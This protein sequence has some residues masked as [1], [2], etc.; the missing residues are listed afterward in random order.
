MAGNIKISIEGGSPE[1]H[2][3]A[4][5]LI[6]S[7]LNKFGLKYTTNKVEKSKTSKKLVINFEIEADSEEEATEIRESLQPLIASYT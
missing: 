2:H 4:I 6:A 1:D 7:S 5:N 3:Q